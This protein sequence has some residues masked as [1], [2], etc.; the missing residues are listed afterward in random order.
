MRIFLTFLILSF[1]GEIICE[2]LH[3]EDHDKYGEH[4]HLQISV[5][6]LLEATARLPEAFVR[7]FIVLEPI[8]GI[9]AR[10]SASISTGF[11]AFGDFFSKVEQPLQKSSVIYD[12]NE[13]FDSTIPANVWECV[14]DFTD[15][16]NFIDFWALIDVNIFLKMDADCDVIRIKS[17]Q[18]FLQ[19][20]E[21]SEYS[22]LSMS[23]TT[24]RL[25]YPFGHILRKIL[26]PNKEIKN[27][28]N[29]LMLSQDLRGRWISIQIRGFLDSSLAQTE[30]AIDCANH[31]LAEKTIS[32]IFFSTESQ[33]ISDLFENRVAPIHLIT[34]NRRYVNDTDV[35]TTTRHRDAHSGIIFN[36]QT[37]LEDWYLIG[38][39]PYCTTSTPTSLFSTTAMMRTS[40]Q[41]I[42]YSLGSNCTFDVDPRKSPVLYKKPTNL[43][44]IGTPKPGEASIDN[45]AFWKKIGRKQVAVRFDHILETTVGSLRDFWLSALSTGY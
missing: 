31:L 15:N 43:L 3:Q 9:G 25:K 20:A 42:P 19:I 41:Y 33:R 44:K 27:K 14:F 23:N 30:L 22:K 34:L 8:H 11:L 7:K 35:T 26:R 38:E 4:D 21:D 29:H 32:R 2:T 17:N 40:C 36:G 12:P 24:R 1:L 18:L 5:R 37:S 10:L 45:T 6:K 13:V 28:I 39:A 16:D